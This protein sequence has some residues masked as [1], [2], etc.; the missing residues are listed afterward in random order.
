MAHE[1]LIRQILEIWLQP[2][3]ISVVH[4][5]GNQKGNSLIAQGSRVADK[6]VGGKY[7][8]AEE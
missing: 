2:D 6:K 3:E 5:K 1:E 7:R 8:H 4:I